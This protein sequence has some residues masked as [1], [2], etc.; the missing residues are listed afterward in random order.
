MSFAEEI[1]TFQ[2]YLQIFAELIFVFQRERAEFW[3][4]TRHASDVACS[5]CSTSYMQIQQNNG[6][7]GFRWKRRKFTT[8]W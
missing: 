4:N 2:G 5:G 6:L 3:G 1:S 7:D 8:E